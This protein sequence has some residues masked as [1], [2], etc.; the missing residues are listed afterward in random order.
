MQIGARAGTAGAP[1]TVVID[2]PDAGQAAVFAA[3]RGAGRG[4]ADFYPLLLANSVLGVGS[5]GRLFEEV[6]TKRALSY[7][8]YSSLASRAE[9]GLLTASAQT[10]NDSAADVAQVFLEQF[11]RLGKEPITAEALEK[12]RLFLG[13]NT[14]RALETSSGFNSLVG[15]LLQQGLPPG[16]ALQLA[17][18]LGVVTPEAASQSAA[19]YITPERTTLVIVGDAALFLD[20]LKALRP[21]VTVIKASEVDLSSPTLG[22][23]R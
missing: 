19:R 6:R 16:E 11:A 20:K 10:K 9:A 22:A 18:R 3:V 15:Q 8:A 7:G 13:G 4:E 21:D 17:Q 14:Q 5:N 12:R 23:S 2:M 1:R